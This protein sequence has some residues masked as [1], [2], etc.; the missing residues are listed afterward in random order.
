MSPSLTPCWSCK[1]RLYLFEMRA[2]LTIDQTVVLDRRGLENTVR[3]GKGAQS[4]VTHPAVL[5]TFWDLSCVT[6]RYV[7]LA[8]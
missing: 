6:H 2:G 1:R 8:P 3:M 7:Q 5:C 4:R